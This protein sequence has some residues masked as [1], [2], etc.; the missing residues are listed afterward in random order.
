MGELMPQLKKRDT[1]GKDN[2]NYY[3]FKSPKKCVKIKITAAKC[4]HSDVAV[5]FTDLKG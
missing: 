1:S 4:K 3:H 2:C 5:Q